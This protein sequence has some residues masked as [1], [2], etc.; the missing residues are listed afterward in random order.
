[1]LTFEHGYSLMEGTKRQAA[2]TGSEALCHCGGARRSEG[3]P[4]LAEE[5]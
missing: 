5:V 1:M 4:Q 2:Y 3:L